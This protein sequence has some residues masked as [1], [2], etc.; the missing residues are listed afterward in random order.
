[1]VA[2]GDLLGGAF[3]VNAVGRCRWRRL[4]GARAD[5][6]WRLVASGFRWR[7]QS[8]RL[9]LLPLGHRHGSFSHAEHPSAG[10]DRLMRITPADLRIVRRGG[11]LVRFAALGPVAYV[12]AELDEAGSAGT[13]LEAACVNP[14]WGLV[15]VG[16][17]MVERGDEPATH[18]AAGEAFHV[19]AGAPEHR[20][21]APGRLAVVGFAPLE[22]RTIDDA[23]IEQA[24]F[25]LVQEAEVIPSLTPSLGVSVALPSDVLPVRR[26][27]I[28]ASASLMGPWVCCA[29]RFGGVSGYTSAWCDL[30]HW[31]TVV[32]G[33]I[34]IEWEDSVEIISA[35]DAFYCPAGP[36]GHRIEVTDAATI[37]D[38]TP[39]EAMTH[40]GR[41]AEWRPRIAIAEPETTIAVGDR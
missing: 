29:A 15:V 5:R 10:D 35:G 27:Q 17:L 7:R 6:R 21:T 19:R 18:I 23:D 37:L 1:V 3:G 32:H 25:E 14:H 24:G 36:P 40:P 34:A 30:P 33:T 2:L 13:A 41:V 11:L 9:A 4:V 12:V 8:V 28:E 31:G 38:F 26:G 16:E 20:F 22:P 39:V